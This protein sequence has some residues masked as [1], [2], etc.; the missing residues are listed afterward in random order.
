[1]PHRH[2]DPVEED[3]ESNYTPGYP[4]LYRY[5][6]GLFRRPGYPWT[7][8]RKKPGQKE[9]PSLKKPLQIIGALAGIALAFVYISPILQWL[10][11]WDGIGYVLKIS[12]ILRV[13]PA[14][15][16]VI[17]PL[18]V[19]MLVGLGIKRV[20]ERRSARRN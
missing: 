5:P 6:V 2:H 18:L 12:G 3:P 4:W 1:M 9:A 11:V 7:D 15:L 8:P 20:A 19:I 17:A 10:R 13:L 16:K 14:A